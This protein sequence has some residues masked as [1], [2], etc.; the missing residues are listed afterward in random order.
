VARLVPRIGAARTVSYHAL[1][2]AVLL[3]PLAWPH[4]GA[5]GADDLV[6]LTVGGAL[7]GTTAGFA[8]VAGLAVIGGPRASILA[9]CEP[10]VAVLVSWVLLGESLGPLAAV[11]GGLILAAG[12]HVVRARD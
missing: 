7:L 3:L 9:F 5:V 1:I 12:L 6:L 4:L 8:Y 11:G 2:A 10:V